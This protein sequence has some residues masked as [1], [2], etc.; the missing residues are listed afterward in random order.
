MI[1]STSRKLV[2]GTSGNDSIYNSGVYA[3]IR[4]GAGND[5]ITNYNAGAVFQYNPSTDG[6]DVIVGFMADS[7]ISVPN[8]IS[9]YKYRNDGNDRVLTIGNGTIRLKNAASYSSINI[10]ADY[11]GASSYYAE[12]WF[13]ED[14]NFT[15]SDMD[16]II[17][18]KSTAITTDNDYGVPVQQDAFS[19]YQQSG[20][21]NTKRVSSLQNNT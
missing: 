7:K 9:S 15:T 19:I 3:T 8:T 4:G 17:G 6:N 20:I 16:E 12:R 11:H 18:D 14:D 21:E 13:D 10:R 2:V 5:T 1:N